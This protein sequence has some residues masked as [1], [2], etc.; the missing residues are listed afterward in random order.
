MIDL[1]RLMRKGKVSNHEFQERYQDSISASYSVPDITIVAGKGAFLVDADGKKYLD[2]LSGIATNALGA[3]HPKIIKAVTSQVGKVSHISNFYGNPETIKLAARLQAISGDPRARIFF[4]NSG[5]EANEAAIKISRLTGRREI[6]AMRG[7]FHGRTMGA[8]SLTGQIQKRAPFRPLLSDIRFVD[9]GD[10]R[11]LKNAVSSRTAMIIVEPIQGENGV[12]VPP[13]G[14]LEGVEEVARQKGALLAI[15]AV[16]TGMGRTGQW[17]GYEDE[18]INPDIVTLAKGLGGGLPMG[19]MIAMASAP[20]FSPGQHGTTFGGN[21]VV[22]AAANVVIDVIED[23]DLMGRS[24]ELY[25][26]FEQEISKVPGVAEV[27]GKGLLIGVVLEEA[28]A[29]NV[30]NGLKAAGVLAN[31]ATDFVVRLAPP[32]VITM[33]EARRFISIFKRVMQE[34]I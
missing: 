9:F 5:A 15:D 30:V 7:A 20:Q 18:G 33:K 17:F 22:A 2:F 21:P 32:L 1:K 29:K 19:A 3:A 8:L 23:E 12:V 24:K 28:D 14:Y 31:A 6:I 4:C 13:S 27:R 16:Q 10:L 26:L 11:G 34:S 25:D